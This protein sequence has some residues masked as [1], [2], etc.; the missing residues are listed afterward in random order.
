M[1]SQRNNRLREMQ[2]AFIGKLMA[3]L[4]HENKN[5]LAIIKESC[6]LIEDLLMIEEPGQPADPDRSGRR[7]AASRGSRS[8]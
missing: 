6:G 1:R 5:H 7:P 3:S 8:R 2:L 4:S